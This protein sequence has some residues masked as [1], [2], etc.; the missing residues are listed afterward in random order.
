MSGSESRDR[1][2]PGQPGALPEHRRGSEL[3]ARPDRRR[4]A[5]VLE[6]LLLGHRLLD[7]VQ[8]L[9]R[10]DG[11]GSSEVPR[12]WCALGVGQ[13]GLARL[14]VHHRRLVG[15]GGSEYAFDGLCRAWWRSRLPLVGWRRSLDG[16]GERSSERSAR[17][18][19]LSV[20]AVTSAVFATDDG[21]GALAKHGSGN[22]L[23][24]PSRRSA[25]GMLA[26]WC[27]ASRP[28]RRR[29][30]RVRG[31]ARE[32]APSGATTR[33]RRGDRSGRWPSRR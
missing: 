20:D 30:D 13:R 25:D 1:L 33:A 26:A 28:R 29:Q 7:T 11:M 12:R 16:D 2:E 31:N 24:G 22:D 3:G 4:R 6:R 8:P 15:R 21:G 10:R 19:R 5:R 17:I 32:A 14:P 9:C 18:R 27:L 23:V